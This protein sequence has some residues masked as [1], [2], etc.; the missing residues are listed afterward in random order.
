MKKIKTYRAPLSREFPATHPRAGQPTGFAEKINNRLTFLL[1]GYI[2]EETKDRIL[3][4]RHT[5]RSNYENWKKKIDEVI[6]GEAILVLYE[7]T[8][9]PYRD[10]PHNIFV[11]YS[12]K[13]KWLVDELRKDERYKDVSFVCDS[14]LG[15]QKLTV[16]DCLYVGGNPI[17]ES[18]I[19]QN[20]GLAH[21]DFRYWLKGYDL[22]EPLAIIHFT[23]F[24]Y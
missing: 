8:G 1:H 24:R 14:G 4:K 15:V 20:D 23:K 2:L 16:T 22:S 3:E 10:K 11:F 13:S 9:R 21:V 5:C 19:A 12:S 7:W 17:P 6:A 18:L